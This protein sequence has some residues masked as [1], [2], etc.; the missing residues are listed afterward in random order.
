MTKKSQA[1]TFLASLSSHMLE[2]R[3]S[4]GINNYLIVGILF[5][6]VNY[7]KTTGRAAT[8]IYYDANKIGIKMG[9]LRHPLV[10]CSEIYIFSDTLVFLNDALPTSHPACCHRIFS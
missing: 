3:K 8:Y 4:A 10:L 1:G 9:N 5:F 7:L 6:T 2:I